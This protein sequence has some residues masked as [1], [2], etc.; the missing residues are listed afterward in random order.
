MSSSQDKRKIS[1]H[2][3]TIDVSHMDKKSNSS[4]QGI[5]RKHT[6]QQNST[7]IMKIKLETSRSPRARPYSPKEK[8]QEKGNQHI[9]S[10]QVNTSRNMDDVKNKLKSMSS[11]APIML[12]GKYFK[13]DIPN[14]L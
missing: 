4:H 13:K 10:T 9:F 3:K 12:S 2:C 14:K 5:S 1:Q 6:V 7:K 8:G 11:K